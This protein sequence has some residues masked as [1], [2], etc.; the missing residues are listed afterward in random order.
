MNS[1]TS[2]ISGNWGTSRTD[3]RAHAVSM[4]MFLELLEWSHELCIQKEKVSHVL[5]LGKGEAKTV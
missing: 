5:R 1:V 2:V 3:Q 4:S